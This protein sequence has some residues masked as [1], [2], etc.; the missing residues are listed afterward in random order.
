VINQGKKTIYKIYSP[1]F[2]SIYTTSNHKFYV[3]DNNGNCDWKTISELSLSNEY[4]IGIAIPNFDTKLEK[5]LKKTIGENVLYEYNKNG[6]YLAQNLEIA[7]SLQMLYAI[8]YKIGS[9][10]YKLNINSDN[11]EKTVYLVKVDESIYESNG[12]LWYPITKIENMSVVLLRI[13][14]FCII[15]SDK[16]MNEE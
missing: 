11:Q 6:L 16:K 2:S 10:I 1:L 15:D 8:I 5:T 14:S 9:H 3:K 13:F 4:L 12:Y 7:L